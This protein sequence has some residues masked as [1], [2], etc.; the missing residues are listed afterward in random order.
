MT[1]LFIRL[2]DEYGVFF[3]LTR[4]GLLME[5][6]VRHG[7]VDFDVFEAPSRSK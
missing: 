3:P 7:I 1:G 6:H 2:A 4:T 5:A